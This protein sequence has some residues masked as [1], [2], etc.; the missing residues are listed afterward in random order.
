MLRSSRAAPLHSRVALVHIDERS[1][2]AIGQ[3]PSRR[4]M[5][6]RLITRLR[7]MGASVVVHHIRAESHTLH[8]GPGLTMPEVAAFAE[9]LSSRRSAS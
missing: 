7:D 2:A 4:D 8:R 6:A 3:W 1:L 5:I 9:I